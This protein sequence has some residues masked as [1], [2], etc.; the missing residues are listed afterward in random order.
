MG[1]GAIVYCDCYEKG[2]VRVPPPQPELVYVDATGRR[3]LR[4]KFLERISIGFTIG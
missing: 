3:S 2:R 4:W 1:L